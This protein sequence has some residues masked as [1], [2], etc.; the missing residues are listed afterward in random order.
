MK[1]RTSI[2]LLATLLL[3]AASVLLSSCSLLHNENDWYMNPGASRHY[4]PR[5]IERHGLPPR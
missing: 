3:A 4:T 2:R 1:A 5:E